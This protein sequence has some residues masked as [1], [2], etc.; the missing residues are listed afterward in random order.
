M[1]AIKILV[2]TRDFLEPGGESV[3]MAGDD[4]CAEMTTCRPTG[5]RESVASENRPEAP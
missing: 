1:G 5:E 2:P 3:L 4:A